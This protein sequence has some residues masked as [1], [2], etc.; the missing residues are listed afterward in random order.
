MSLRNH[1]IVEKHKYI[2]KKLDEAIKYAKNGGFTT[3]IVEE[4]GV[5]HMLTEDHKSDRVNFRVK[6]NVITDVFSG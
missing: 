6:N 4:D 1:G 3:R 5:A 2:G